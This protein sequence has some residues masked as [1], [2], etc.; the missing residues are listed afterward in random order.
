MTSDHPTIASLPSITTLLESS[1]TFVSTDPQRE[2]FGSFA[3]R[4]VPF[5]PCT[6]R[7]TRATASAATISNTQTTRPLLL[8]MTAAASSTTLYFT[9]QDWFHLYSEETGQQIC[10]R[11]CARS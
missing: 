8:T 6:A 11:L 1:T 5:R 3:T 7:A 2:H 4:V 9:G 10:C